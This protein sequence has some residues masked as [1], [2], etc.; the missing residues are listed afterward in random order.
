MEKVFVLFMAFAL[1]GGLLS[2][3]GAALGEAILSSGSQ[4]V[5]LSIALLG[6]Y[7]LWCGLLEVLRRSGAIAALARLMRPLMRRLF[8][9]VDTKSEAAQWIATN[10]AANLLGMGNAATPAGLSAMRTLPQ[11]RK[12][13]RASHA[14]CMF[15]IINASSLQLIPTTAISMRA[16]AG[17]AAPADIMLPTLIATGL[18]TLIG[19]ALALIAR[20]VSDVRQ[21]RRG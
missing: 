21:A 6:A 4:A 1:V 3:Q 8:P 15:L 10:F 17:S 9:D 18:A 14:M 16:A 13:N 19:I 12:P 20:K 7:C 11:D 2:G 5:S